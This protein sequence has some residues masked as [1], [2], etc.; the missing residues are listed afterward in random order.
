MSLPTH[1]CGSI[2]KGMR[3]PRASRVEE[4]FATKHVSLGFSGKSVGKGRLCAPTCRMSSEGKIIP[5]EGEDFCSYVP[6]SIGVY[7]CRREWDGGFWVH[8]GQGMVICVCHQRCYH[9]E[10][11]AHILWHGECA[12]VSVLI[13][14]VPL[15]IRQPLDMFPHQ[16][17]GS[18]G[19]GL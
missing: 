16:G 11:L 12:S 3:I 5:R 8:N 15:F 18:S 6:T 7:V 14:D 4:V 2:I 19:E 1:L 17:C 9:E 13:G 10:V